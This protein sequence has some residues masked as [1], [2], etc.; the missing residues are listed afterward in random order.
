MVRNVTVRRPGLVV[1]ASVVWL[2]RKLAVTL[3]KGGK[4]DGDQDSLG[5]FV[6]LGVGGSSTVKNELFSGVG[7]FND[8]VSNLDR[9]V[10]DLD[11]APAE[12]FI[13]GVEDVL[14]RNLIRSNNNNGTVITDFVDVRAFLDLL[15][16]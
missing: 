15:K 4:V 16:Q 11:L 14:A 9:L 2:V 6:S 5:F 13:P 7:G 10:R 3:V 12:T 8:N 1:G